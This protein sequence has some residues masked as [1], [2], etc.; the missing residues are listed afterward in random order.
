MAQKISSITEPVDIAP[1]V[2]RYAERFQQAAGDS[3]HV[4]SPLGAWLLLALC[5]PAARGRNRDEIASILGAD[6]DAAQRV[7][8]RLLEQPHSAVAA[9]AALWTRGDLDAEPLARF[10]AALPVPVERGG[11]IPRQ[12]ELDAWAR[13]HTFGL[14]GEFPLTD[15]NASLLLASALATK[16]SWS[17]PFTIA[18]G[19]ALGAHSACSGRLSRVLRS[20]DDDSHHQF[21]A[22]TARGGDVAVHCTQSS[23][24]LMVTS[25]IAD[26]GVAPSDVLASAHEIAIRVARGEQ[27][28][29][30]LFDLPLG[31]SRFWSI[32]EHEVE[33]KNASAGDRR[34]SYSTVIPAWRAQSTHDLSKAKVGFEPAGKA[35]AE[36]A[37]LPLEQMEARQSAVARYT[38]VGFEAAAV[39]MMSV[40][41]TKEFSAR[42]A[43][44]ME[45]HAELRF[46][47]PFA[48]VAVTR[49]IDWRSST[50]G[51]TA[52]WD[53]VPVF[54]A[55][56]SEPVDAED[57]PDLVDAEWES[58]G[59]EE[60][61]SQEALE[62][63][64]G[65]GTR[66]SQLLRRLVRRR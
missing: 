35:L 26:P 10:L 46:G 16:V 13:D 24:G 2:C 48:V 41:F 63:S 34:E 22:S 51:E 61:R 9:A 53:A 66:L 15:P 32:T 52:S 19:A 14:I 31:D 20:P 29:R 43:L 8:A 17:D 21:I 28:Q 38:R 40:R 7:A 23:D 6:P 39:T 12:N 36:L 3:H 5:V 60:D 50:G 44:V 59:D 37:G 56:V 65:I 18:P 54:Y 11:R 62:E 57:E 42:A 30:S 45:R 49:Q 27:G 47:H 33:I 58:E 4:A 25:V 1:L 55:W 64:R